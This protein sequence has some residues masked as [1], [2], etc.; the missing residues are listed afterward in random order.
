MRFLGLSVLVFAIS[1][2]GQSTFK[3]QVAAIIPS[4]LPADPQST[5]G[6][7]RAT[8]SGQYWDPREAISYKGTKIH[9]SKGC[10]L[11]N[12]S[13]RCEEYGEPYHVASGRIDVKMSAT[14]YAGFDGNDK[15]D[16]V[17]PTCKMTPEWSHVP[18]NDDLHFIDNCLKNIR[19]ETIQCCDS[20][21]ANEDKVR[22]PY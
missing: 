18:K 4:P 14:I 2:S 10:I 5:A 9:V 16:Y 19:D 8:T 21:T 12:D 22:N 11:I 15:S 3:S 20:N 6:G 13:K 7:T 1:V 17:V